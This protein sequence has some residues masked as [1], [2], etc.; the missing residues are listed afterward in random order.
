MGDLRLPTI[1][2]AESYSGTVL[3]GHDYQGLHLPT[4]EVPPHVLIGLRRQ[5]R[6]QSLRRKF[7]E[8]RQSLSASFS[9]ARFDGD[10]VLMGLPSLT[11]Q[12]SPWLL[13]LTINNGTC[14]DGVGMAVQLRIDGDHVLLEG[15]RLTISPNGSIRQT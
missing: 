4:E 6:M 14:I 13:R 2:E 10:W 15:G 12:V 8:E 11:S 9:L 3:A 7:C 5:Q 1:D